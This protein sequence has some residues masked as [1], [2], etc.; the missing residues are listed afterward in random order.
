MLTTF[1][2]RK[3]VRLTRF[4]T[5]DKLYIRFD[6]YLLKTTFPCIFILDCTLPNGAIIQKRWA[7]PSSHNLST[8]LFGFEIAVTPVQTTTLK[9]NVDLLTM[10]CLTAFATCRQHLH[11]SN[12]RRT[13]HKPSEKKAMIVFYY[14]SKLAQEREDDGT[15]DADGCY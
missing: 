13:N 15:A 11:L 5:N 8:S 3:N 12:R 1:L 10:Q 2:R 4:S 7:V 6:G 14:Y 9:C